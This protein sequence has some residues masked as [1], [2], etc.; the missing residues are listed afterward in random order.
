M[1]NF[2]ATQRGLIKVPFNQ[3]WWIRRST[4]PKRLSATGFLKQ[5]RMLEATQSHVHCR[6]H[7]GHTFSVALHAWYD[8]KTADNQHTLCKDIRT[9]YSFLY[10]DLIVLVL[11]RCRW[12]KWYGF[13]YLD[14]IVVYLSI[15]LQTVMVSH[16]LYL[17]LVLFCVLIQWCKT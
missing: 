5:R 3:Y 9:W 2:Q 16:E 13:L 15:V 4:S 10:K 17:L 11:Q 8:D 6:Y 7:D 1:N 12:H 14:L